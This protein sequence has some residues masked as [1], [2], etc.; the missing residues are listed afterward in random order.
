MGEA[1][2]YVHDMVDSRRVEKNQLCLPLY[3]NLAQ[4]YLK[5]GNF[6]LALEN[7]KKAAD[8][9]SV[10]RNDF[11]PSHHAKALFRCAL[12]KKGLGN[13]HEAKADLIQVLKLQ[14]ELQD[15]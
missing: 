6:E 15:A 9:A 8:I 10:P 3:S 5:Q 14:P 1:V 12:V 11:H 2:E 4:V 7:A 13:L